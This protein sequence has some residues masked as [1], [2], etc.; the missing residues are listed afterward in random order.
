MAD[1]GSDCWMENMGHLSE[2]VFPTHWM[3]LPAP[4]KQE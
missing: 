4:P 1:G 2:Q 3:P